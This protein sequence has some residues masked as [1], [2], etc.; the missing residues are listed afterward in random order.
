MGMQM[1]MQLSGKVPITMTSTTLSITV[2]YHAIP[3]QFV[4]ILVLSPDPM[5]RAIAPAGFSSWFRSSSA[6][7]YAEVF[8]RMA[9]QLDS[10]A[11]FSLLNNSLVTAEAFTQPD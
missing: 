1:P 4:Y 9:T 10:V 8:R 6:V 3:D 2:N 11:T 7:A 5:Q